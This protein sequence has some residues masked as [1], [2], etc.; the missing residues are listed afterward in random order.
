MVIPPSL[1][2][3]L[4]DPDRPALLSHLAD[5][6]EQSDSRTREI[7]YLIE[8]LNLPASLPG[9]WDRDGSDGA[10]VPPRPQDPPDSADRRQ[11]QSAGPDSDKAAL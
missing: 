7:D 3:A 4:L 11:G 1:R 6:R 5:L 9:F 10:T 8:A 2:E